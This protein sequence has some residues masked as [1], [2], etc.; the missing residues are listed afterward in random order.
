MA[1]HTDNSDLTLPARV[2]G[3]VAD[4]LRAGI[5]S[6]RFQVGRYLPSERDMAQ[7]Y[8]VSAR[9]IRTALKLLTAENMIAVEPRKGYRVISTGGG[10]LRRP[11][12]DKLVFIYSH[13]DRAGVDIFHHRTLLEMQS[14][15]SRQRLN[16]FGIAVEKQSAGE[17]IEQVRGIGACGIIL[18][19]CNPELLETIAACG[20]PAVTIDSAT[21]DGR[22]DAVLQ[23]GFTGAAVATRWILERGRK[24]IAF[25]G[26]V[27]GVGHSG[28]ERLGGVL[29]VLA[30]AGIQLPAGR[31]IHTPFSRND[32]YLEAAQNLLSLPERPDGILALWQG[33]CRAIRWAA[34]ELGLVQGRDLDIVG[35]A[36]EE[37]FDDE[38]PAG[39]GPADTPPAMVWSMA[40]MAETC[41]ARLAERL[42][43]PALPTTT[44]KIPANLRLPAV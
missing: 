5:I 17:I 25:F 21:P 4:E 23:D 34:R 10:A 2:S 6:G 30:G 39:Y 40:R 16:L 29:A 37:N 15:A 7:E 3:R 22:F 19:T 1:I 38:G 20:I 13:P 36:T 32:A 35:W 33:P 42:N 24:N 31:L 8:K 12:G 28:L 11:G 14:A 27:T 44:I 9:S 18:N 43:N 41:L 26:H